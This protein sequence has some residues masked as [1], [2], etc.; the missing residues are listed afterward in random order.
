MSGRRVGEGAGSAPP[1]PLRLTRRGRLVVVLVCA[2]VVL[3]LSA[4]GS[5]VA[6]GAASTPPGQVHETM[7]VQPGQTLWTIAQ[8]LGIERDVREVIHDIEELN[9]LPSARIRAGQRLI[10]PTG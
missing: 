8:E 10:V 6:S 1:A 7:I 4:A 2:V 3:A 5:H 9:G